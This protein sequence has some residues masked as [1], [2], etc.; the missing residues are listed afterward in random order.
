MITT[1]AGRHNIA[2][3]T[4]IFEWIWRYFVMCYGNG[5]G[6]MST[7]EQKVD[8]LLRFF[9]AQT[10][11]ERQQCRTAMDAI[12]IHKNQNAGQTDVCAHIDK[13]LLEFG[14]PETLNGYKYIRSCL[15]SLV[16]RPEL[17]HA[18]TTVLYPQVGRIYN[19]SA[20][21]VER[22]IRYAVEA[23]WY[24]CDVQ[25]QTKYFGNQIHPGKGKPTNTQFLVR[26]ANLIRNRILALQKKNGC[27][28]LTE[29]SN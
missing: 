19:V 14:V 1:N 18:V 4:L 7:L 22:G 16:E 5:M 3:V 11:E 8:V 27:G 21:T 17:C 15:L 6:N 9:M 28:I 25:M 20:L 13:L 24:N 2:Q 23:G 12:T 10:E 26:M 29:K